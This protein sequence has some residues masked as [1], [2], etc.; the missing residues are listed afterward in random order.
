M[1]KKVLNSIL[2]LSA[3]LIVSCNMADNPVNSAY[4]PSIVQI[5]EKWES[6]I[7][8]LDKQKKVYYKE[9]DKQGNILLY[10]EFDNNSDTASKSL[11][12]YEHNLS[13]EQHLKYDNSGK[14]IENCKIKYFYYNSKLV[15]KKKYD[16][17]GELQVSWK[18]DYN[19]RG[20][21]IET[22]QKDLQKGT[23]Y[24]KTFKNQYNKQ[25]ELTQISYEVEGA[26]DQNPSE[27]SFTKDS[28]VYL[29]DNSVKFYKIDTSGK[30]NNI[31]SYIYDNTGKVKAEIISDP[32]GAV[33]KRYDYYY[34]Y[35][36]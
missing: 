4:S 29:P 14:V 28:I 19:N 22:L 9:F 16:E 15:E 35:F 5:E 10:V 26:V 17:Q 33:K 32:K 18:Y 3:L 23:S 2:T 1:Y 12:S 25:G 20:H 21:L 6:D 13:T 30:V 11:Y 31:Y 24:T 36:N 7:L 8:T 27:T 34:A